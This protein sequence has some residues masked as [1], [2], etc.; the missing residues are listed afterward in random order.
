[1]VPEYRGVGV[2]RTDALRILVGGNIILGVIRRL[3][4]NRCVAQNLELRLMHGESVNASTV[5]NNISDGGCA[6]GQPYLTFSGSAQL[7]S[8]QR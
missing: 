7:T 1:M 8:D 4:V 6:F 3:G 2:K 5:S